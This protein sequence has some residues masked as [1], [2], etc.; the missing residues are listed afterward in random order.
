MKELTLSVVVKRVGEEPV[1]IEMENTVKAFRGF[2]GGYL[3]TQK[4]FADDDSV[5]L[6]FN[7]EAKALGL[8]KN[9]PFYEE[10]SGE[11]LD[12]IRGDFA[13]VG[14]DKQKTFCSLTKEQIDRCLAYCRRLVVV[15]G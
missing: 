2:V 15:S 5:L 4:V 11:P 10:S 1:V 3:G 8:P 12:M 13:F 7:E 14:C 9:F 6:V